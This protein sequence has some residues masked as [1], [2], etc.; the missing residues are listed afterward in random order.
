MTPDLLYISDVRFSGNHGQNRKE[1]LNEESLPR[2]LAN[3]WPSV[4][5]AIIGKLKKHFSVWF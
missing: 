2:N 4:V 3:S 1:V 5:P